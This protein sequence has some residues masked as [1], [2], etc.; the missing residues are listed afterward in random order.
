MTTSPE[1]RALIVNENGEP[2]VMVAIPILSVDENG[3][4]PQ[5]QPQIFPMTTIL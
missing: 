2:L 1:T 3:A 4:H 5:P